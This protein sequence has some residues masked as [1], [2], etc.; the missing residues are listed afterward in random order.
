M[1]EFYASSVPAILSIKIDIW[2]SIKNILQEKK[3]CKNQQMVKDK[4][5]KETCSVGIET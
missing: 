1:N 5:F 2:I 4:T 3:Y